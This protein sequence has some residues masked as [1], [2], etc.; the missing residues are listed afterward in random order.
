M[1]TWDAYLY[2]PGLSFKQL[3]HAIGLNAQLDIS[4]V[5]Q[6]ESKYCIA[7]RLKI[8]YKNNSPTQNKL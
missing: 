2:L 4:L 5:E 1:Q 8:L 7:T 6:L 3:E